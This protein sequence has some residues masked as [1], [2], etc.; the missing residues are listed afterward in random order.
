V[1]TG[2]EEKRARA[3]TQRSRDAEKI[4]YRVAG[5]VVAGWQSMTVGQAI[6][7]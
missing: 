3:K 5:G 4:E 2:F 6:Y 1:P 7:I